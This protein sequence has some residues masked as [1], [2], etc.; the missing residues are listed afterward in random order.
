MPSVACL[1]HLDQPFLGHAE[2]PLRAA[3]I[4]LVEYQVSDADALPEL[5]ELDGIISFGGAQ[6]AIDLDAEPA[7][8][9]EAD[10]LARAVAGD[11]PVLG[12]CLGGQLLARALGAPVR[13]A[14][15]RTVAWRTLERL[16][17]AE[18]DALMGALPDR[19][20]ALHWNED[21]FG[22][23][24]GAVELLGPRVEGVE[25]FR[26]GRSAYGLQF[27][28][29][30]DGD[31]LDRWYGSYADWLGQARIAEDDARAA[32]AVN[33]QAQAEF[34][35]RLFTAFAG[36]VVRAARAGALA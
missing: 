16:P 28:P 31:A 5:D 29:E 19:I 13:R 11:V 9:A 15:G 26:A 1:H 6:S 34:A 33:E 32:D 17:G 4:T 30:V 7:L 27:H 10:L 20:P 18:G 36:L 22:L 35:R 3:G 12:L 14:A 21:V 25:A 2:E 23:P 24:P 8:R